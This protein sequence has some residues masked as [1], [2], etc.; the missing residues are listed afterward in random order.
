MDGL[1]EAAAFRHRPRAQVSIGHDPD[2]GPGPAR[3]QRRRGSTLGHAHRKRLE[4]A[5]EIDHDGLMP[6][7][8][9]GLV[10]E[11]QRCAQLLD[12]TPGSLAASSGHVHQQAVDVRRPAL[13]VT[14]EC[15]RQQDGA[16]ATGGVDAEDVVAHLAFVVQSPEH[17]PEVG[18][19][20]EAVGQGQLLLTLDPELG[21]EFPSSRADVDEDRASRGEGPE[22]T[23]WCP[24]RQRPTPGEA[25]SG[26]VASQQDVPGLVAE[27]HGL[28]RQ[29]ALDRTSVT[30]R[31]DTLAAHAD[32]W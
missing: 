23:D 8:H 16:H 24:Q 3:D 22:Q 17:T 15:G 28:E 7:I 9:D 11:Q 6:E 19:I 13:L 26:D 25:C 29:D 14:Y 32:D 27:D 4:A 21:E 30:P 10:Q 12:L 1:I 31:Q 5:V 20:D 18:S 2:D